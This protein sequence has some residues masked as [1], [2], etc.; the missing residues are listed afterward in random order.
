MLRLIF[1]GAR[2][3]QASYVFLVGGRGLYVVSH[4]RLGKQLKIEKLKAFIA[5]Y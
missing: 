4:K 3:L 2:V 1:Q 5:V